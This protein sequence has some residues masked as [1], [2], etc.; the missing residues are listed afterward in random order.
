MSTDAKARLFEPL[1][2][3][4]RSKSPRIVLPEADSF[5]ITAA[6]ARALQERVARPILIGKPETVEAHLQKV[7]AASRQGLTVLDADTLA[8]TARYAQAYAAK[9]AVSEKVGGRLLKRPLMY[10]AM[11]VAEGDADG[12][13][14]GFTCPT[15]RVCEAAGLTVGLAEGVET[16]SSFFIMALPDGRTFFFADCALNI[17]PTPEQLADIAV[18]T[19]R[20]ASAMFGWEPKVAML[21]FST[22]GSASHPLVDHVRKATEI[23][24]EKAAGSFL[25][26]GEMQADAA[27]VPSVCAKKAPDSP[28]KGGANILVF[29]DLDAANI[30]YK[31]TQRLAGAGA[32]GPFLQGYARPVCD[33]SRGATVEDIFMAIAVTAAR[34]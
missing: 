17:A 1:L 18:S 14:A 9:R 4:A 21:S 30:A 27:I 3:K 2:E 25:V 6:G 28:L 33:L 31:L 23:T 7:G 16:P 22:R 10:A 29:P 34:T 19:A 12:M 20:S 11:M 13:V 15:A 8:E 26:D 24:R 5:E 32:Y